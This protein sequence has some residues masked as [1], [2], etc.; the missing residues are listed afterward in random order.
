MKLCRLQYVAGRVEDCPEERCPF[1]EPERPLVEGGCAFEKLDVADHPGLAAWL[2][3]VRKQLED[4]QGG[5]RDGETRRLFYR[6]LDE[7]S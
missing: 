7:S 4:A 1:W 6:L 2:L 3:R 5:A